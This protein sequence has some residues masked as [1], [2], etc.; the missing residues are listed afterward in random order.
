MIVR[1]KIVLTMVGP[2]I[3]N[4]AVAVDGEQ[5]TEVGKFPELRKSRPADEVVDLGEQALLPGLI[6]AHCHLDY[7]CLRGR[8]S[9]PHSFADWIRAI[10]AEKAKLSPNDYVRSIHEGFAEAKKFGTT[11]IANLTAYPELVSRIK[12]PIR[13]CWFAELIDVRDPSRAGEIVDLSVEQLKSHKN[14]GLAPH[15][16]FTASAY[17]YRRCEE[18]AERD[19]ILLTT[20]LAESRE[21][22]SMFRD[23]SGPLFEFLKGIGRDMSDC[24]QGTPVERFRAIGG[25]RP[26]LVVHLNEISGGD[27]ESLKN[28]G[29]INS[30]VHCPRSH[31]YFGHSRFEFQK[32]R[33]LGFNICLGTDS[34]ASNN[35]LSLFAEM[36]AFQ[37]EFP[38]VS[39]EHILKMVTLNSARALRQEDS[40][41]TLRAGLIADL[42]AIPITRSTSVFDEIVAFDGPVGWSMIGGRISA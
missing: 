17:L 6:N 13:T 37:N 28:S 34:L 26:Y 20:H 21:E 8:I 35:D 18:I 3:E 33:D 30:I 41:G 12:A 31:R 7:T 32:L 29:R 4:G 9:R 25:N 15:A 22:M 14:W 24:G 11:M 1:A 36:R 40:Q 10:N 19:E 42:I 38:D 5:I 23:G 27:L 39:A 16:P 2:P